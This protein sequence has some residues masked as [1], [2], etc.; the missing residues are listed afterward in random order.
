MNGTIQL[1]ENIAD[2]GGAKI[3][4]EAY[5]SWHEKKFDKSSDGLNEEPRIPGFEK[6]SNE[7]MFW[8]S[9]AH[10]ECSRYDEEFPL[11]LKHSFSESTHAPNEFRVR[12]VLSNRPEFSTDFDCPDGSFM[13]PPNKCS[14]W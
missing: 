2:N 14:V 6:Y 3:A 10:N 1:P 9:L 5:K 12:G 8:I 4:Y 13:N 7:Q 11:S